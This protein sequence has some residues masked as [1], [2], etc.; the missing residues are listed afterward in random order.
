MSYYPP[1][2]QFDPGMMALAAGLGGLASGGKLSGIG[3][4]ANA[5]TT[6]LT[7]Q[8]KNAMDQ[9]RFGQEMQQNAQAGQYRNMQMQQ[10]Q[11]QMDLAAKKQQA[12]HDYQTGRIN[13]DTYMKMTDPGAVYSA[14]AAAAN[15]DAGR[16]WDV[17]RTGYA[18]DLGFRSTATNNWINAYRTENQRDPT[19]IDIAQYQASLPNPYAGGM[20][21]MGSTGM[22]SAGAAPQVS[23]PQAALPGA[24][25]INPGAV[26]NGV[27]AT[28]DL[29]SMPG[30]Q[31]QQVDPIDVWK[32]PQSG[33]AIMAK[34]VMQ[35]EQFRAWLAMQSPKQKRD[36]LKTATEQYYSTEAV[37][38]R[39]KMQKGVDDMQRTVTEMANLYTQLQEM[40]GITDPDKS[41]AFNLG[42]WLKNTT[43]GQEFQKAIGSK[44]QAVRNDIKAQ[45]PGILTA[46]KAASGMTGTELNSNVELQFYMKQATDTQADIWTNLAALRRLSDKFGGGFLKLPV[47]PEAE[48]LLDQQYERTFG[49]KK[50]RSVNGQFSLSQEDDA[51]MQELLKGNP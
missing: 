17:L 30:Q 27:P 6:F 48:A 44:E 47:N 2:M 25:V 24:P 16:M 34:Q 20:P 43:V 10:M 41:S 29:S 45:I 49:N 19:A 13:L 4:G 50:S 35:P 9:A 7:D 42:A 28:M 22:P 15:K 26:V 14:Q 12:W 1:M 8:Q 46:V 39:N 38:A 21:S 5:Y 32:N 40:G 51:I 18:N 36:F 3:K 11:Q 33:E 31:P 37:T 23:P